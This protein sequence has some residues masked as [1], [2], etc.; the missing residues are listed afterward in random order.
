MQ[1]LEI[2]TGG[3][4]GVDTAAMDFAIHN[5]LPYRGYC[6]KGRLNENGTIPDHYKLTET[7]TS[8]YQERTWMNVNISNGTLV[9]YND[10][11]TGGTDYTFNY[12]KEICKPVLLQSLLNTSVDHWAKIDS[13][14]QINH[15]MK[16]NVA[17][18]RESE[19]NI[20]LKT[21]RFLNS[22]YSYHLHNTGKSS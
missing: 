15:I 16:M 18:P 3:Q 8:D 13:W 19:G 7:E 10:L 11:I 1:L 14:I 20:Y 9:L 2:T 4:S 21:L 22:W 17:G 6:P 5:N 12:C